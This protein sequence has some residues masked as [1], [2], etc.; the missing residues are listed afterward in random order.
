MQVH[1][2]VAVVDTINATVHNENVPWQRY[3]L[4]K[5]EWFGRKHIL[6]CILYLVRNICRPIFDSVHDQTIRKIV[7]SMGPELWQ[8]NIHNA[9]RPLGN[10]L[11]FLNSVA[12]CLGNTFFRVRVWL[13]C[14]LLALLA[15]SCLAWLASYALAILNGLNQ[16]SSLVAAC[17]YRQFCRWTLSEL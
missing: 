10:S 6:W 11:S 15:I 5:S 9:N 16:C 1:N 4:S 7:D 3:R 8:L 14:A 13:I 2:R 17:S 12:W